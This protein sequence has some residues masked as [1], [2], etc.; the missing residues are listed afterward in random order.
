MSF[1]LDHDVI[2]SALLGIALALIAFGSTTLATLIFLPFAVHT[3]ADTWE[4]MSPA[5]RKRISEAARSKVRQV[6]VEG[7]LAFE[8][9]RITSMPKEKNLTLIRETAGARVEISLDMLSYSRK[10]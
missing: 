4:L 9:L 10:R 8:V 2:E 6:F 7:D 3:P 1:P 5:L